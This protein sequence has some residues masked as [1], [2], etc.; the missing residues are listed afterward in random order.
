MVISLLKRY[1]IKPDIIPSVETLFRVPGM[2][3][4]RKL[5]VNSTLRYRV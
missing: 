2:K 4:E 5:T 1:A 3:F